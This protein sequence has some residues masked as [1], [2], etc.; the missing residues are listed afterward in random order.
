MI[1]SNILLGEDVNVDISSTINNVK[2]GDSCKI[3]KNCS[4]YG[5]KKELL[6]IGNDCYI[7][8]NTIINGFSSQVT[9]GNNVSI[10]QNV[11]IMSDSGPNMSEILQKKYPIEKKEI[12]IGNHCWIGA[13][14]ILLPGTILADYSI[15]G[16]NSIVKGIFPKGAVIAGSL[17]KIIKVENYDC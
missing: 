12:K 9:I 6:I 10:A 5:S 14:A 3:S 11:N 7:G 1:L 17:A 15:V 16:A 8:M 4:I 13:G 2:I